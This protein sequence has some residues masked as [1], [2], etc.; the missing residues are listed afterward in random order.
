MALH[1]DAILR[2]ARARRFANRAVLFL[3]DGERGK[4]ARE[5]LRL[6]EAF[7]QLGLDRHSLV[8]A[9]GGG[10]VGDAAGFAAATFMRGID[11]VQVP[12]TL[13]AMADSSVGGKTGLNLP[14]GKNMV[15]AFHQPIGVIADTSV[16]ETLPSREFQ[17]G[18]FEILKC[19]L[20]GDGPLISL[21]E[22]TRGLRDASTEELTRALTSAIRLKARI[23]RRDERESGERKLLNLG[24]TLGHALESASRYR[25]FTHGEAVGWGLAFAVD[26]AATRGLLRQQDAAK[27]AAA[28]DS[29]GPRRN[30]T[31][32]KLKSMVDAI[33]KDKKRSNATI[34]EPL[35]SKFGRSVVRAV[36]LAT[37]GHAAEAWLRIR[38]GRAKRQRPS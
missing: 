34:D 10:T 38:S 32:I 33:G 7:I 31:G 22:K 19:G 35:P 6:Q 36:P 24:H 37:F 4:T 14:F 30:I 18:V 21:I 29:C 27:L 13:L 11:V 25:R 5:W 23:V 17:S 1:G 20:I 8:V 9:F 28:I 3:P 15:G 26:Y 16:L 2:A 12:T